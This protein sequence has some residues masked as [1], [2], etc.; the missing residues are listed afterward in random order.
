[1]STATTISAATA[2]LVAGIDADPVDAPAIAGQDKLFDVLAAVSPT[3]RREGL[4]ELAF[5]SVSRIP[6]AFGDLT[7][8][9]ALA[10][11]LHWRKVRF[12]QV[13]EPVCLQLQL[14]SLA[15]FPFSV[16][17]ADY[18]HYGAPCVSEGRIR[19]LADA[20]AHCEAISHLRSLGLDPAVHE[21]FHVVKPWPTPALCIA[22]AIARSRMIILPRECDRDGD[23]PR[24]RRWFNLLQTTREERSPGRYP[25]RGEWVASG[26]VRHTVR[27]WIH[28]DEAPVRLLSERR[29]HV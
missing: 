1:M 11:Y 26:V 25:T 4:A 21:D 22:E 15:G 14:E 6:Q 19:S 20:Y 18:D 12:H 3:E 8:A 29:Q 7:L 2:K 10:C 16:Y 23:E 17:A 28:A 9:H 24:M 27:A 13:V 5:L